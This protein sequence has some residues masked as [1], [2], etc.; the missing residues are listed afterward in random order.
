MGT[1]PH[2]NP[3]QNRLATDKAAIAA[4]KEKKLSSPNNVAHALSKRLLENE[5]VFV[6]IEKSQ[7]NAPN[8]GDGWIVHRTEVAISS[9][10]QIVGVTLP[11]ADEAELLGRIMKI[12]TIK[13]TVGEA[14]DIGRKTPDFIAKLILRSDLSKIRDLI[15]DAIGK[16]QETL[17][18]AKQ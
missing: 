9:P 4:V 14:Q 8:M 15:T 5:P 1:M 18:Q 10:S 7:K 3:K 16:A 6:R 12:V 11:S 13:N 2:M 17:K